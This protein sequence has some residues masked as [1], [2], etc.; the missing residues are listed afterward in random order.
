[1]SDVATEPWWASALRAVVGG[2]RVILAGSVAAVWTEHVPVLRAAGAT[3]ILVVATEGPGTGPQPDAPTV[4][5]AVPSSAATLMERIH[6]TNRTLESPPAEVLAAVS[7]FDRDGS[8]V[9]IGTFLNTASRLAGRPFLSYRRPE[10]VALEDKVVVD[11]FWDRAG[12]HRQP[13]TVVPLD[14]ASRAAPTLDL[15]TGTVWA[16]DARD[17]FHGGAEHTRWV[18]DSATAAQATAALADHCDRVRVMPFVEGIPCSIH[19]IV[20][21]DGV[22]VLRPVEMVVLRRQDAAVRELF[23]AGCATFWDPPAAIREQMTDVARRVGERLGTEV[24]FRGT[25]TVDGVAAADGFWPTELNPRF[26]AGINTIARAG[27]EVPILLVNEV[28]G[29]GASL[30]ISAT[31]LEHQLRTAADAARGGGTWKP[32][33][34]AGETPVSRPLAFADGAWRWAIDGDEVAGQLTAGPGLV[35]CAYTP[36]ATPVG[37]S[38]GPRAAAFWAFADRELGTCTGPLTAAPSG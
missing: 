28:V 7:D 18:V 31:D 12:V 9:V 14:E 32:G 22:A 13:S 15:G 29:S 3:E 23:Y 36:E 10:W 33:L 4:I 17:G 38:T 20:L 8:A 6:A 16:A 19:G 30:G 35:R 11:A 25:F 34:G 21:P 37:P 26:G 24:D 2:R 1:M 5:C 27:G